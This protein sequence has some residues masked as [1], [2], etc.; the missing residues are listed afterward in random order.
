MR[1]LL[2]GVDGKLIGYPVQVVTVSPIETSL[3]I[4]KE[5]NQQDY[6]L[7]DLG[8]E[9]AEWERCYADV[10]LPPSVALAIDRDLTFLE[11]EIR[12]HVADLKVSWPTAVGYPDTDLPARLAFL[13]RRMVLALKMIHRAFTSW[14]V[15]LDASWASDT[16]TGSFSGRNFNSGPRDSNDWGPLDRP[17]EGQELDGKPAGEGFLCV[18]IDVANLA[19]LLGNAGDVYKML[20][21]L[22]GGAAVASKEDDDG[23]YYQAKF[24]W[25]G[26]TL[27]QFAI[28]ISQVCGSVRNQT[29]GMPAGA[30]WTAAQ[31][32]STPQLRRDYIAAEV[33]KAFRTAISTK[34]P[35]LKD[36]L[37]WWK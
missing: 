20:E 9:V 35:L 3:R 25:A 12:Q 10:T 19:N 17:T 26:S 24:M 18:H 31:K 32:K 36:L 4:S 34:N 21:L 28:G 8:L 5:G 23:L 22:K 16:Y 27:T 14:K 13:G 6:I 11:Q 2:P 37:P 15:Y 33:D 7:G 1:E 30:L 29:L